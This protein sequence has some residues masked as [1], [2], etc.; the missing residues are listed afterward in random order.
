MFK[1]PFYRV[2][3]F[4]LTGPS[5]K[6]KKPVAI[7]Y[8]ILSI[9]ITNYLMLKVINSKA[10]LT[11]VLIGRLPLAIYLKNVSQKIKGIASAGV[12]FFGG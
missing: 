4:S 12:T 1:R 2:D 7:P 6:F 8:A 5:R 3:G 11:A 9:W 10:S